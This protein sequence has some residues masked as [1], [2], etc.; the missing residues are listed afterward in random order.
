MKTE[1]KFKWL[2]WIV[3]ILAIM[4]ISTLGTIMYNRYISSNNSEV[5]SVTRMRMK[6][7][8]ENFS[9]RYFRDKLGLDKEQMEKFR[10]INTEFRQKAHEVTQE[11]FRIREEMLNQL[12]LPDTDTVKLSLLSDSI[13]MM[14]ADL[15][16]LS[17]RYYLDVKNICR[18][19]QQEELQFI[20]RDAF[21][22]DMP[23]RRGGPG[24]GPGPHRK[25]RGVGPMNN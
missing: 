4:N 9:G 16:K 19:D 8:P 14:H 25:Q 23:M 7:D 11:L 18:P 21:I 17:F 12:S 3:V 13:G 15:K 1:S 20:F 10:E 6:N 5:V 24:F 22:Q 2:V